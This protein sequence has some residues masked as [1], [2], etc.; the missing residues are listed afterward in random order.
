MKQLVLWVDDIRNPH[1]EMWKPIVTSNDCIQGEPIIAWVKNYDEF[2][3]WLNNAVHDPEI[4]WPTLI[5]FDH[6]LGEDKSGLDCTK[7]LVEMCMKHD[8]ELPFYRCHSSNPV[9][10]QNILSYLNSYKKSLE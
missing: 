3:N 5:C 2:C 10:V 8:F 7:Y 9:G 4:L 1:S 6:D